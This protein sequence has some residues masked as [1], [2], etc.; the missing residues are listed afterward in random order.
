MVESADGIVVPV[1]RVVVVIVDV[2]DVV[3]LVVF[4]LL[5]LRPGHLRCRRFHALA[6]ILQRGHGVV[7]GVFDHL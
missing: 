3:V 2:V 1:A 7:D 5:F 6:Q 4:L